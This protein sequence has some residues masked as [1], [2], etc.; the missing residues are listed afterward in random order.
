[1]KW[2]WNKK[3]TKKS[4]LP[5]VDIHNHL[6]PGVDDGAKT[7]EESLEMLR[8]FKDLGYHTMVLTPHI[9]RDHYPN[10][11]EIVL[12]ETDKLR[13]AAHLHGIDMKLIAGA[14]YYLDE[15]FLEKL[16]SG[17]KL[18]TFGG[19]YVLFETSFLSMP[20]FFREA[21]FL[22][23]SSG[24]QPVLA[25]PERYHY[26]QTNPELLEEILSAKV[27][28]QLNIL[29]MTGFYSKAIKKFS[30]NLIIKKII[31]FAAS[32]CHNLHQLDL[33]E[34]FVKST[35]SEVLG[36][37]PLLNDDIKWDN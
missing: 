26:L 9:M 20:V 21:V 34:R 37:L 13:E 22:M 3:K 5:G 11:E 25:H 28:L 17:Q 14:E 15:N 18:L 29:S 36:S 30:K 35:D 16:R 19:N 6:L 4:F 24:Y 33:L 10:T 1:M 8:R 12:A 7:L 2:G 31:S 27:L 23:N 32:D